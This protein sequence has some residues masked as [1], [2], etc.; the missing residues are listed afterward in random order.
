MGLLTSRFDRK[1]QAWA[2]LNTADFARMNWEWE[3]KMHKLAGEDPYPLAVMHPF[4]GFNYFDKGPFELASE[5]DR[6]CTD[7]CCHTTAG[8][9]RDFF[10]GD[11]KWVSYTPTVDPPDILNVAMM[12]YGMPQHE[13][14]ILQG[15]LIVQSFFEEYTQ[16]QEPCTWAT[17]LPHLS[18]VERLPI[19][20]TPNMEGSVDQLVLT[21]PYV[22]S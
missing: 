1:L 5:G 20:L 8:M 6:I 17:L 9:L 13:V 11:A 14:I 21:V 15:R 10:V 7:T 19:L 22:A 3:C 12:S 4:E 2:K 16:R 18:S